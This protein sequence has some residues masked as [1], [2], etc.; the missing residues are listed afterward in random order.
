MKTDHLKPETFQPDISL[1]LEVVSR[2][3]GYD[4]FRP[5][6][7]E[8]MEAA[9]SG[10]DSLVVLPTGGGKSL[11]YQAPAL[12]KDN[13]TVVISP[14]ISLM[15]DQVDGLLQSGVVAAQWNSSQSS[16]EHRAIEKDL[17]D[18]VIRLLFVSPERMAIPSF[19]E[20]LRRAGA[21]TFAIDEA[22]CISHWGH[23]FRP[24]YRQLAELR[25]HFPGTSVHAYTAT[26]TAQVRR[27]IIEQLGL[28]DPLVLVGDF[29]RPNLTYR[30]VRRSDEVR[31]VEEVLGRHAAEAGIVY[32]IRRRDVDDL[33]AA[34]N[35][36][37]HRAVAYH[38]GLTQDQRREAQDAFSTEAC[39]LVIATVAFGMGIDRSNVR[40]VVH[41]GMP[42]SIEHYQQETGR[43]GRDGLEAEC[44][45]LYSAGDA[46]VWK[47]VMNNGEVSAE[48]LAMAQR[49]IDIM[50]RYAASSVCRHRALVRHFGQ[51]YPR[52]SCGACDICH[53]DHEAVPDSLIIAQKILSCVARLGESFGSG[54]VTS[55]LRG[56]NLEKITQRR[57]EQL[58]T[59]GLLR[60]HPKNEVRDWIDQL[61]AEGFLR[62]EGDR[63]P[64]LRMTE[65]SRSLL[66]GQAAVKLIR[67]A[68][69]DRPKKGKRAEESWE[70]VDRDLFE[71]LRR[72]RKQRADSRGLPPFVIFSDKTLRDLAARRPSSL[73]K[74]REVY[75][76]GEA[77]LEEYGS[78]ILSIVDTHCRERKVSRD[79][80]PAGARP[81][82]APVRSSSTAVLDTAF[83]LFGR[84]ESI[85]GVMA[86]TARSRGTVVDYLCRYIEARR[87]E[88]VESWIDGATLIKIASAA[89]EVGTERLKPIRDVVG[90]Q[91]SYDEIRIVLA[92]LASR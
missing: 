91:I 57:H 47:S 78:D 64:L 66:K 61:V 54:Y 88:S 77:K 63:Y 14:L 89:E 71:T 26:A 62:Q 11:C 45:L 53:G 31:Q 92:W 90:E 22:H 75:G 84:G 85:A 15:K 10:R 35:T 87:P 44:V 67:S 1:L 65:T 25:R 69:P 60:E 5:L 42:K 86:A 49:Q 23:D 34:L 72:W 80:R 9:L 55:V 58:S 24:E 52:D 32:C 20:V 81:V 7:Q 50:N 29:D 70:L 2:H 41:T 19:R 4:T 51:E 74:L 76:I 6:Q 59:Y 82:A 68:M 36:R 79:Q 13:L 12:L 28:D 37:G 83:E 30:I 16:L 17:L 38:A 3:W 43:A 39:D 40:F 46:A 8:A 48:H 27:D 73:E 56:E 33:T 21:K 18:G